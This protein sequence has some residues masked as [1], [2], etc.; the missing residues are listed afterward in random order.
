MSAESKR[1]ELTSEVSSARS[2]PEPKAIAVSCGEF[3]IESFSSLGPSRSC[4]RASLSLPCPTQEGDMG[5]VLQ[6][7]K[8]ST[9]CFCVKEPS[10][11]MRISLSSAKKLGNLFGAAGFFDLGFLFSISSQ[12]NVA[13]NDRFLQID[14]KCFGL[15]LIIKLLHLY[16]IQ[17]QHFKEE[18]KIPTNFT[19]LKITI[20][21]SRNIEFGS[22]KRDIGLQIIETRSNNYIVL[23]FKS[24]MNRL[25]FLSGFLKKSKN[26]TRGST[27]ATRLNKHNFDANFMRVCLTERNFSVAEAYVQHLEHNNK[28]IKLFAE[29]EEAKKELMNF[30]S[31]HEI[32]LSKD[33][34]H[35]LKGTIENSSAGTIQGSY[36]QIDDRTGEC[37]NCQ[38]KL[39]NY[40]LNDEQF[41]M[42]RSALLEK[43]L[44]GPDVYIGSNPQELKKFKDFVRKTSPYDVVIDGLNVIYT[45]NSKGSVS[46]KMKLL[47]TVV[48]H[49]RQQ[50]KKVLVLGRN[51]MRGWNRSVVRDIEKIGH[52]FTTENTSRDDPFLLYAALHSGNKTKFLSEDIMRDHLYRLGDYDLKMLFRRWQRSSQLQIKR[53]NSDGSIDIREPLKHSTIS[54]FSDGRWHIPYDDGQ[55]RYSYQLPNTWLCLKPISPSTP[56]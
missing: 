51:H 35:Q 42:L 14:Y 33:L 11:L 18:S 32:F 13:V 45:F 4:K 17:I 6:V 28:W 16:L 38:K 40:E 26:S 34:I 23:S 7:T 12:C 10:L 1:D 50:N 31:H 27:F 20:T 49:F 37:Q 56:V 19:G 21:T 54:Q 3:R 2:K 39:E 44:H 43:V 29:N 41:T 15:V 47:R 8:A 25:N 30:L 52:L 9:I 48:N 5:E 55:L 24:I 22:L 46:E 36:T 53:V